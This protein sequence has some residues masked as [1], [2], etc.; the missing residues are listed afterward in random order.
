MRTAVGSRA[1]W[2]A[3]GTHLEDASVAQQ[4]VGSLEVPVQDPVVM[5]VLHSTQQLDHQGLYLPWESAGVTRTPHTSE[6][7]MPHNRPRALQGHLGDPEAARDFWGKFVPGLTSVA[8]GHIVVSMECHWNHYKDNAQRATPSWHSL[9]V[10]PTFH[11]QGAQPTQVR[12][13]LP[14]NGQQPAG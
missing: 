2:V 1:E 7:L 13:C 10:L 8:L 12:R 5:Q 9:S 6:P 11:N 14:S 3:G 4:Q